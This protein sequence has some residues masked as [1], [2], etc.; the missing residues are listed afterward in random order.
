MIVVMMDA[1]EVS[2]RSSRIL[3]RG[4]LEFVV[5]DGDVCSVSWPLQWLLLHR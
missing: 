2:S 5:S 3:E 1:K 4:S